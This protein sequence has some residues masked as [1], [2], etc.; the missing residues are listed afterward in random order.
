MGVYRQEPVEN[1][2]SE[3]LC[4]LDTK[5][6]EIVPFPAGLEWQLWG[7]RPISSP[8]VISGDGRFIAF[9][10]A[11]GSLVSGDDNGT[12]D[13]FVRDVV[14]GVTILASINR[15]GT[16]SGNGPSSTP[17]L[18]GDGQTLMFRSWASDLAEGDFNN[19][20]DFF[21]L[22]LSSGD[23]D[24]D[25]LA[26]DWEIA[27]FGSLDRDGTGDFDGDGVSDAAEYVAGTSPTNGESILRVMILQA[28]Q[29]GGQKTLLWSAV[30]GKRYHVQARNRVGEGNWET[31]SEVVQPLTSTGKWIDSVPVVG[32]ETYYRVVLVE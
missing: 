5:T 11:E 26:D 7:A 1:D 28:G 10:S 20:R 19:T 6:G 14:A 12:T 15:Q 23:T 3:R 21:V 31:V 32:T 25:G 13:V 8:P 30:P 16:H 9:E 2:P 4:R 22:K 17:T 29:G 24:H 27:Y 18:G